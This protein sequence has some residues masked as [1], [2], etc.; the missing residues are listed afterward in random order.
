MKLLIKRDRNFLKV[1]N[2]K[3]ESDSDIPKKLKIPRVVMPDSVYAFEQRGDDDLIIADSVDYK[4]IDEHLSKHPGNPNDTIP[5]IW[6]GWRSVLVNDS[7][8]LYKLKGVSLDPKNPKVINFNRREFEVFGGQPTQSAEFEKQMSD[9]F[10]TVL[11]NEGID[12]LMTC[13]GYWHYPTKVKGESFSASIIKVEG[14]TRLD[15]FMFLIENLF[16]K[17]LPDGRYSRNSE[18]ERAVINITHLYSDM[19]FIV[20]QLKSLMDRSGQT[21]SCDNERSNAHVGNMILYNGTGKVKLGFGDFDA[22]CDANDFSESELI[23]LQ[24]REYETIKNSAMQGPIS[25]RTV[26]S[27]LFENDGENT[28]YIIYPHFR[29]AFIAGFER[30]YGAGTSRLRVK[31]TIDFGRFL[32]IFKALRDTSFS[33]ET[34]V[35]SCSTLEDVIKSAGHYN[36]DYKG[37]YNKTLNPYDILF[38]NKIYQNYINNF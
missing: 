33:A 35:G 37:S 31:N 12:L 18:K 25:L 34:F 2:G 7:G 17:K 13:E 30:G 36:K 16:N 14:D 8:T 3:L 19:G 1:T 4:E 20:G 29:N 24:K 22:S 23:E 38:N 5:G 9:R 26:V 21:W 10:N 15:E 11:R 27:S 32:E 28:K 6:S